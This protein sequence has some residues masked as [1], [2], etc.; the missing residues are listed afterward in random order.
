MGKTVS[1]PQN[2][3]TT[4]LSKVRIKLTPPCSAMPGVPP[5]PSEFAFSMFDESESIQQ[6][7]RKQSADLQA[8]RNSL[9]SLSR[10]SGKFVWSRKLQLIQFVFRPRSFKMK[11]NVMVFRTFTSK[12][13][14]V[15]SV[16]GS[17]ESKFM[18]ASLSSTG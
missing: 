2:S 13:N 17:G 5:A 18:W 11:K 9:P 15:V 1:Q 6:L 7:S 4:L 3:G 10:T 14:F 12:L 8:R 16:H